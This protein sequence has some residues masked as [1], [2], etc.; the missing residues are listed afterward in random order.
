MPVT[1]LHVGLALVAKAATR[2]HFSIPTFAFAQV[3]I[4][5]EVLVGMA[6]VGDLSYHAVL[7]TFAG[8]TLVALLTV[9]LFGAVIRPLTRLWNYIASAEP[10][11][12]TY[13]DPDVHRAVVVW[14]AGSGCYSHL[15]L[16]AVGNQ[17]IA[18][19]APL[20]DGNLFFGLLLPEE[21]I[22]ACI[23]C[24]GIGGGALMALS[25]VRRRRSER[26]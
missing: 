24:W 26:A 12:L 22:L 2:R 10:G 18:P 6:F 20:S 16:D 21:V 8:T 4:D 13:M 11:S 3:V 25:Y 9:L 14:S 1:P 19:F 5:S 23:L 15:L 17:E 7:H